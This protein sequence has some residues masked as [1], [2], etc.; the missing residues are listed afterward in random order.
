MPEFGLSLYGFILMATEVLE[1]DG[2]F[3]MSNGVVIAAS[4]L[5][6]LLHLVI[7]IILYSDDK[8]ISLALFVSHALHSK[9]LRILMLMIHY[10]LEK[11]SETVLLVSV[12]G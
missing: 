12:T 6:R 11:L 3:M 2:K 8:G 4:S 9:S 5:C 1:L 7:P 10:G